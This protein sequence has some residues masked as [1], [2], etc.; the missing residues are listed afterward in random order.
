MLTQSGIHVQKVGGQMG[1]PTAEDIAVQ[2]GR[3]CRYGGAIW[4]PNLTHLVFVGLMAYKRS[5]HVSN[6]IWGFLHDAH[7]ICTGEVPRPFK[8]DCMRFEQKAIDERILAK[9]FGDYY[10]QPIDYHLVKQCDID[11]CHIEATMLGLPGFAETEL[12]YGKDYTQA[13][14]IHDNLA[15]KEL[16]QKLCGGPFYHET[17]AFAFLPKLCSVPSAA[18]TTKCSR[19]SA[20][21]ALAR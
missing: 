7:E 6:L 12:K 4:V 19:T 20:V 14:K 18:N 5:G 2:S 15:D 11:V 10:G 3:V 13:T 17:T 21:G 1:T 16:F 8:C 9:F